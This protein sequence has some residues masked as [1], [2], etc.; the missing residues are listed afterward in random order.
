MASFRYE[1]LYSDGGTASGIVEAA[2]QDD[3]VAIIRKTCGQV[4]MI[5]EIPKFV[6]L[7]ERIARAKVTSKSL[8]LTCQQ[9]GIILK[10]GLPL[11]QTVSLVA[12]QTADKGMKR[13][14]ETIAEN[15]REGWS[16]SQSIAEHG[17]TFPVTFRET[18]RA[19]EDS[20]D[21]ASSFERMAKY[22]DRSAKTKAKAV[23]TLT[24]PAFVIFVAVVVV[25]I[26]MTFAV[27]SFTSTFE[28]M[29][30]ELPLATRMLI[31]M[32]RFATEWGWLVALILVV[33]VIGC[34][35]YS[36][37]EAGALLFS[38]LALKLPI[39]GDVVQMAG[40]SQFAHTMSAMLASGMQ[41]LGAI[42]VSGKAVSSKAMSH[43]I[44]GCVPGVEAGRT[45]G[46][47]LSE[48][49]WIPQMLVQMVGIG[50]SSGSM[51]S[52]LEVL[53]D[54]YDNEV[55]VKSDRALTLLE[56]IIICFLAVFVVLILFAVYLP[57]FSMSQ[58]ISA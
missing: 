9:F 13:V 28:S 21:L 6:P 29:G 8:A 51:E 2:T 23:S 4:T 39:I 7:E 12:S 46:G 5:K 34:V 35:A 20:G 26:I 49:T 11:V 22:Y 30:I 57:M 19:G 18:I 44:L 55:Q 17:K 50:E 25:G 58:G 47:C 41:I 31:G 1:G 32:S 53:A 15:I 42:D 37:T 56:P 33:T 38:K 24:Y 27:P 36:R 43:E 10:A 14:L 52:T 54:Y 45:L 48:T 40:A 3:A 16:L